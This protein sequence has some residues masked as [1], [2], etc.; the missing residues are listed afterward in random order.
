[1]QDKVWD[2]F[3]VTCKSRSRVVAHLGK[4]FLF[5]SANVA[6]ILSLICQQSCSCCPEKE[7][8]ALDNVVMGSKHGEAGARLGG[9][10]GFRG[11]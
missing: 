6:I 3:A 2:S 9:V 4:G 8:T 1:M 7:R 5:F 11:V 10:V